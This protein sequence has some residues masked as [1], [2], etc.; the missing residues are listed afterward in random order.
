MPSDLVVIGQVVRPHGLGGE[1][2][3][4]LFTESTA[5]FRQYSSIFLR[6]KGAPEFGAGIQS[7]RDHKAGVLMKFTGVS[8]RNAAENLVGAQ[9]LVHRDQ[10]PPLEDGE[11]YWTDLIGLTVVDEN[12]NILGTVE[13]ILR[14]GQDDLLV[15]TRPGKEFLLPFREEMILTV[16]L[17]AGRLVANPPT[18]LLDF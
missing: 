6:L 10:M 15:V 8:N 14:A 7:V 4:I 9:I 2:K 17:E 5:S 16:D 3:A 11:F 12:A 13:N 1:V 18:G